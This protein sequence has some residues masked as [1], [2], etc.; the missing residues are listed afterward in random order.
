M[1]NGS[2]SEDQHPQEA[3]RDRSR[4]QE[5]KPRVPALPMAVA[6]A[7]ARLAAKRLAE[8]SL[9]REQISVAATA[10]AAGSTPG[11]ESSTTARASSTTPAA[12]TTAP[13]LSSMPAVA[14]PLRVRSPA[15]HGA[16]KEQQP[17]LPHTGVYDPTCFFCDLPIESVGL[18]AAS[19]AATS[20]R[21][22]TRYYVYHENCYDQGRHKRFE[23]RSGRRDLRRVA[24]FKEQN[25]CGMSFSEMF[26]A[27][28]MSG[29]KILHPST[30]PSV[31]EG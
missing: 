25:D 3:E 23:K 13:A 15:L 17:N 5:G 31:S 26:R 2:L 4:S 24:N 14:A 29:K 18:V 30:L 21:T 19:H 1:H 7:R 28:S 6:G 9:P 16:S 27:F 8:H 11:P 12:S 10:A 20:R 22:A